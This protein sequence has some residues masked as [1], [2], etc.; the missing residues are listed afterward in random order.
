MRSVKLIRATFKDHDILFNLAQFYQY[1][2]TEFLPGEVDE[3]GNFPYINIRYYLGSG[4]QAYLARVDERLAGFALVDETLPHRGGPGRYISE[5]FVM[6]GFRRQ[7]IGRDLAVQLFDAY[8]G[9]WEIA[10]IGPNLPAQA[11]WRKVIG[12]YTQGRY[13]ET[14]S[15]DDGLQIVWQMFDSRA[16]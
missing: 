10:E 3:E 9:C 11:F 7:G 14:V 13:Q 8:K 15:S 4:R 6:R 2:F 16:W 12:E 5:F 1:D